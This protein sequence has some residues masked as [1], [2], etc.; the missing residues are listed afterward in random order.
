MAP[1]SHSYK[2]PTVRSRRVRGRWAA[3]YGVVGVG[4]VVGVGVGGVRD[5]FFSLTNYFLKETAIGL[6]PA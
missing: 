6:S 5:F 2:L 3:G 1:G 4:A